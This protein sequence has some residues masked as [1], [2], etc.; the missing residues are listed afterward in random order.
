MMVPKLLFKH[1]PLLGVVAEKHEELRAVVAVIR[2]GDRT[3]KQKMKMVV[4]DERLLS[5]FDNTRNPEKE[6]KLKKPQKL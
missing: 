3:P 4:K 5:F 2:H 6:L 1:R